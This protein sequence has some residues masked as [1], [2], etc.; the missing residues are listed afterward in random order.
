MVTFVSKTVGNSN[1]QQSPWAARQYLPWPAW[2]VQQEI[3]TILSVLHCPRWPR[4][5]LLCVAV[6]GV[7]THTLPMETQLYFGTEIALN[8]SSFTELLKILI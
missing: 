2:A 7:I 8:E 4:Q 3:E 1:T 6:A 5:V